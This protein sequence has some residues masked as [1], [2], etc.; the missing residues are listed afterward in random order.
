MK[1]IFF[2]LIFILFF[3]FFKGSQYYQ[4]YA[5]FQTNLNVKLIRFI[6]T[7][8]VVIIYYYINIIIFLVGLTAVLWY[9]NMSAADFVNDF[10]EFRVLFY[11]LKNKILPEIF[12]EWFEEAEV[13]EALI[14]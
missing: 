5:Q 9:N 4:P 14:H 2:Y 10:K 7:H 11:F 12:P 13:V 8:L 6:S 1:S 3:F